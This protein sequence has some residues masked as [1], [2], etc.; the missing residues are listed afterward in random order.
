MT[1]R[2]E[3]GI[4][5]RGQLEISGSPG[6]AGQA[7]LSQGPGQLPVWTGVQPLTFDSQVIAYA[8]TVNLDMA[9]LSGLKRTIL[10]TGPLTLTSSNRAAGRS[11]TLRLICD[12]TAR[13]LTVPAGWVF[14]GP[15]GSKPSSIAASKTAILSLEWYGTAETDCV[16]AYG[17]QG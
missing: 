16:A 11:V 17:V 12:A 10:L 7:P 1:R 5:L 14:L 2:F 6:A 13:A 9:A 15:A 3:S 4:D 8:A